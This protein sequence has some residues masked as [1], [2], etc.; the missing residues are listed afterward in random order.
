MCLFAGEPAAV[1]A[2]SLHLHEDEAD[3]YG[4]LARM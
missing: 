4:A 2:A 3:N 1:S